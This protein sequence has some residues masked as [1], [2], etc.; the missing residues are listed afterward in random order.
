MNKRTRALFDARARILKALG[1]PSRLFMVNELASGERCVC[2]L[3]GMIEADMSTASKHLSVLKAA[4]ILRDEKRDSQV[5]YSL[6]VPCVLG[7]LDCVEAVLTSS[8]EE[9]LALQ[10][11]LV[12]RSAKSRART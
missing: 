5:Y 8:A 6:R 12:T 10:T 1:H 4:G 7:F 11:V 3:A 9:M 2:E